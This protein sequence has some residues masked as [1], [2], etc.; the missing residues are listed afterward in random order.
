MQIVNAQLLIINDWQEI[1]AVAGMTRCFDFWD[2][3]A[4]AG[5]PIAVSFS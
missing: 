4:H 2:K 1:P 3:L 5:A